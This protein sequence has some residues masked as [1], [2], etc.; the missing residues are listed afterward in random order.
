MKI[1][2]SR[3]LSFVIR[4]SSLVGS[5]APPAPPAPLAA[6]HLKIPFC[7]RRKLQLK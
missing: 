1:N 4:H 6:H 3:H 2:V 7:D 5:S